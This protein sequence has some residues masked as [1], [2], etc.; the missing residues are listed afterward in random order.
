MAATIKWRAK[1]ISDF[2]KA[3]PFCENVR[4]KFP[5][6]KKSVELINRR[7]FFSRIYAEVAGNKIEVM[8]GT[9][10]EYHSVSLT[11][12]LADLEDLDNS[13]VIF[14][15]GYAGCGKTVFVQ[16]LLKNQLKTLDYDFSYYNYDVGAF[17]D[18]KNSHRIRDAVHECFLQQLAN[19]VLN[20]EKGVIQYFEDLLKQENISFLDNSC[21]IYYDFSD[22]RVF[23]DAI[24]SLQQNGN[25][26]TFRAALRAQMEHFSFEQ[27]LSL[28]YV[29]RIAKYMAG[30]RENSTLYVCYDNMDAIENFDDLHIFDNTLISMRRNID[31]YINKVWADREDEP[32]R[33]VVLATYRKIT[34]AKVDLRWHSERCDDFGED[35]R[36][37]YYIDAS[38]MY[39][40]DEIVNNRRDYFK[41]II[42]EQKISAQDLIEKLDAVVEI[43]KVGFVQNRYAGLWNNNFRTCGDIMQLLIQDYGVELDGC[44]DLMLSNLDGYDEDAFFYYGASSV[45]LSLICKTFQRRGL[46]G[47]DHMAL[48]PLDES[49]INVSNSR[50]TSLS[51]LI[52]TY[53]SNFKDNQGR[54]LSVKSKELF[55]EFGDLFSG[56][57]ICSSLGN[58]LLRDETHT[59]RRPIYYHRNAINDN[60]VIVESL[61]KQWSDYIEGKDPTSCKYTEILLCDCG[62]TYLELI[63]SDFEFFSVRIYGERVESL[64]LINSLDTIKKVIEDVQNAVDNCC[65]RMTEFCKRYVEKKKIENDKYVDSYIHPR[66]FHGNAQLHTERI[67]FS[68]IAYLDH[69]RRY[70]VSKLNDDSELKA[71]LNNVFLDGISNYLDYYEKYIRPLNPSRAYIAD[72]LMK[73]VENIR[74]SPDEQDWLRPVSYP[75]AKQ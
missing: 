45:F 71:E 69:C 11:N 2:L 60:E 16:N 6:S 72:G 13:L 40:Y 65:K 24:I 35:R 51:R 9:E 50:L 47:K 30:N 39:H 59:W 3:D 57:D 43:L 42:N 32:P 44:I 73:I 49:D 26:S 62:F 10:Q 36:F 33:F 54:N 66:T 34:A 15:E 21:N 48:I 37:L 53:I 52:L 19:S 12:W 29:F 17:Y 38:K 1:D 58:M 67:I 25:T 68:H 46:W 23:S 5:G 28:D 55:E 14:I 27:I 4:I 8:N 18:N 74:N 31:S 56:D 7:T 63:A 61:K 41:Y 70:H 20:G 22:T 64:Y 75:H